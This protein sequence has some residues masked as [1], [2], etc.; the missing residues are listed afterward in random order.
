MNQQELDILHAL[1]Y[2]FSDIMRCHANESLAWVEKHVDIPVK[3][4]RLYVAC[5]ALPGWPN[6][7][8]IVSCAK[9][10][11][12]ATGSDSLF[13][14]ADSPPLNLVEA[15]ASA[16]V[17]SI[18]R[19]E[20]G[21]PPGH[22]FFACAAI[23]QRAY[24]TCCRLIREILRPPKT[25]VVTTEAEPVVEPVVEQLSPDG[26]TSELLP[27]REKG[28]LSTPVFALIDGLQTKG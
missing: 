16:A 21:E 23:R 2:P 19:V 10:L 26:L 27:A 8:A 4:M 1:G 15:A 20:L 3:L 25:F 9:I 22:E 18:C 11:E 13:G 5:R 12:I 7:N 24:T 28:R 14:Q 17:I 6:G